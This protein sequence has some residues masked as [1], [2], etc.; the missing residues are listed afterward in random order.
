ME[1][2]KTPMHGAGQCES[3]ARL[4]RVMAKQV[5]LGELCSAGGDHLTRCM[6]AN[7]IADAQHRHVVL[8]L[9]MCDAACIG[10]DIGAAHGFS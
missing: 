8:V 2:P 4:M 7:G 1:H 10:Q 6:L 3:K 9:A 5:I